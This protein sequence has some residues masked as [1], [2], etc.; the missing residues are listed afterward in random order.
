VIQNIESLKYLKKLE[1]GS[2]QIRRITNINTL[3]NLTQ[4]SLENNE[5]SRL[6]GLEELHNL[7]ELYL[8]NNLIADVKE[9][10]KLQDLQR[11][12]ILDISGNPMSSGAANNL[13]YRIYCIYHLRKLRVLDGMSIDP[14]EHFEAK[15]TFSGR[16]TDEI[17]STRLSGKKLND[18]KD[19][20]LSNSK[21]RDF[22]DMFDNSKMPNL[23]DLNLTG[24]L[25]SSMRCFGFLPNLKILRLR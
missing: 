4:L 19:L 5:I 18:L 12:I 13:N 11:L 24:N 17:L 16:L 2:N 21:L 3:Q 14:S 22:E 9:T 10:I 6:D 25:M 7:M 8:G 23:R 15:E 20:D 1:L